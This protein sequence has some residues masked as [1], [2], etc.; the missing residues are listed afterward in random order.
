MKTTRK[1]FDNQPAKWGGDLWNVWKRKYYL[2]KYTEASAYIETKHMTTGLY[3]IVTATIKGKT[4]NVYLSDV[5]FA[6]LER[7]TV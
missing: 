2:F 3:C 4:Q 1:Q 7:A 5:G 6:R